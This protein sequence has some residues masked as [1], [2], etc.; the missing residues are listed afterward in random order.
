MAK[1]L[2]VSGGWDGHKPFEVAEILTNRLESLGIT[3]E[4]SQD[5]DAFQQ[6]AE[7][8][9]VIPNWTMG[10]VEPV[11]IEPLL[12]AVEQGIGVAGIHGGMGDA[13]RSYTHYQ[14]MCGGQFVEHPGGGERHF[15]VEFVKGH[16]LTQGF[17]DFEAVTESYY[18][19]LDPA[20]K[21]LATT[22]FEDF[23]NT[24]MPV[25]W[26]KNWGDG[27]VYYCSLG[28]S[29]EVVSIPTVLEFIA[30]GILWAANKN[31]VVQGAKF[32]DIYIG[33]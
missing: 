31:S 30:R 26:T 24:V 27:R 28:H 4:N 5:L 32:G 1:A 9:V 22:V 19:H 3:V 21:V 14:F 20:I 18:M 13:F 10:E 11:Q 25:A 2:I 29:P 23:E 16:P 15:Q 8:D 12:Q 6:S 33:A 17:Q 7:F